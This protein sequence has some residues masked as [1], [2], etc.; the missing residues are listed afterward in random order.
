MI[1]FL[2][3]PLALFESLSLRNPVFF[4]TQKEE[5]LNSYQT[6]LAASVFSDK[7]GTWGGTEIYLKEYH[8][9]WL[10]RRR[11]FYFIFLYICI[12]AQWYLAEVTLQGRKPSP[13]TARF[14]FEV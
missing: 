9:A 2:L 1:N 7:N 10:S 6:L 11:A 14:L 12:I 5:L 4:F 3:L 13:V 8:R